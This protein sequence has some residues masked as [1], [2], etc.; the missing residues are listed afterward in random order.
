MALAAAGKRRNRAGQFS[1]VIPPASAIVLAAV[2][3]KHYSRS[4]RPPPLP[5]EVEPLGCDQGPAPAWAKSGDP[6]H[7]TWG[8]AQ[9]LQRLLREAA[10]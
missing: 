1:P 9:E 4:A 2:R 5:L 8:Q 7:D 10:R 6:W 3:L